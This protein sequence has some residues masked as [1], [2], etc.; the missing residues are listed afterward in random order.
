MDLRK[1]IDYWLEGSKDD[2]DAAETLFNNRKFRQALFFVHLSVE[3]ILKAH[4]VKNTRD[5]PPR[6]HD[7]LRLA[8]LSGL[9]IS[10]LQRKTFSRFQFYC[11]EGRYPDFQP[12]PPSE[13]ET[14]NELNEARSICLWLANQLN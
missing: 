5:M 10:D 7:L 6:I 9:A 4:V 1:Q 13:E 11:L 3:K 14:K 2:L 8:N 12:S